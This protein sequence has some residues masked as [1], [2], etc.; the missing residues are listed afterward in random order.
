[1]EETKNI[2]CEKGEGAVNHRTRWFKKFCLGCK[3]I[4]DQGRLGKLK[5]IDFNDVLPSMEANLVSSTWKESGE[6]SISKLCS[7]L[8]S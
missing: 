2:Y 8:P 3:N 7:L 5:T 6:F 4:Y 1:M